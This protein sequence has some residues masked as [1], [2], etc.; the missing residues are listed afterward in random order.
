MNSYVDID[1]YNQYSGLIDVDNLERL[2][3]K[4]SEMVDILT[5]NHIQHNSELSYIDNFNKLNKRQQQ[6]IKEVVCELIDY[7][8][9]NKEIITSNYSSYKINGLDVSFDKTKL[10]KHNNIYISN[11]SYDKLYSTG[12]IITVLR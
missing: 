11:K 3:S 2:L 8:F 6:I 10:S 12:L 9:E 5:D 7:Q 4:G 1:F